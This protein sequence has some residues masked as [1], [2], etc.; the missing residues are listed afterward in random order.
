MKKLAAKF[1]GKAHP[2]QTAGSSM[3]IGRPH[4]L[5]LQ[6]PRPQLDGNGVPIQAVDYEIDRHTMTAALMHMARYLEDRGER[7]TVIAIGGVVNLLLLQSRQAT[8][9]IDFLGTNLDNRQRVLL[10]EAAAYA[11]SRSN[12]PLGSEWFNNQTQMW[13]SPDIHRQLTQQALEQQDVIFRDGPLTVLAAPWKY[14][15]AAKANRVAQDR[16]GDRNAR[17]RPYDAADAAAYLHFY[18]GKGGNR[19]QNYST[20]QAWCREYRFEVEL[21]VLR[22]I[23]DE[24]RRKYRMDGLV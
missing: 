19:P 14:A 20:A 8:H 4:D 21:S 7:I 6:V 1:K 24:Y 15:F 3:Q 16:R 10:D 11:N 13:L 5:I 23:N 18:L 9:D 17:A 22:T 12:T 2:E